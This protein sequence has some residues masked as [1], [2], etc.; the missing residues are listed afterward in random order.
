MMARSGKAYCPI[1]SE[2]HLL[3]EHHING[4]DSSFKNMKWNRCW[5]CSNCHFEFHAG[6]VILEGWISTSEGKKLIHRR[7]GDDPV[8]NEGA[9]VYVPGGQA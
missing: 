5:I 9:K 4:R 6:M 1:C 3:V 2:Q 8:A 7:A